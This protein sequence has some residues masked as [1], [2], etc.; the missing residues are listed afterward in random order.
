ML[1]HVVI[2]TIVWLSLL[3]V[4]QADTEYS[5]PFFPCDTTS[6]LEIYNCNEKDMECKEVPANSVCT[7]HIDPGQW[8]FD[9]VVDFHP[10]Y[11]NY[12]AM[13]MSNCSFTFINDTTWS[14]TQYYGPVS[15]I[16][17]LYQCG[18]DANVVLTITNR[19]GC[20]FPYTTPSDNAYEFHV[21]F[22]CKALTNIESTSNDDSKYHFFSYFTL[23]MTLILCTCIMTI[24]FIWLYV[25][26][27]KQVHESQS[28]L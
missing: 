12:T 20:D 4:V 18:Y 25:R 1:H 3:I 23:S 10:R 13:P 7:I 21:N 19:H 28:L 14:Y 17:E 2:T 6:S 16:F 22:T 9:S 11:K 5:I 24:V 27:G 15:H 8:M 26:K